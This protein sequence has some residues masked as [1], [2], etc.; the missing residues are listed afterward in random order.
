MNAKVIAIPTRYNRQHLVKEA[1][2][3]LVLRKEHSK[4]RDKWSL[5]AREVD[6]HTTTLMKNEVGTLSSEYQ[7]ARLNEL[8]KQMVAIEEE[9]KYIANEF[10]RRNE[11]WEMFA[12]TINQG[13]SHE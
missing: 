6:Y 9:M 12:K 5:L 7:M 13:D 4:L 10:Y 1:D 2:D 3:I 11:N 8:R